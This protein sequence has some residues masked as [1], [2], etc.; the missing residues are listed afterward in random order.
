MA[1][2]SK[3]VDKVGYTPVLVVAGAL[4]PLAVFGAGQLLSLIFSNLGF[5]HLEAF[6]LTI[7]TGLTWSIIWPIM[8]T[9]AVFGLVF[10]AIIDITRFAARKIQA[11]Q[12]KKNISLKKTA[13]DLHH[14]K[15]KKITKTAPDKQLKDKKNGIE[16]KGYDNLKNKNTNNKEILFNRK[17]FFHK[18]SNQKQTYYKQ[19]N[20]N[21]KEYNNNKKTT[22]YCNKILDSKQ[23]KSIQNNTPDSDKKTYYHNSSCNKK[24]PSFI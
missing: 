4:L 21:T 16:L 7:S 15:G 22:R 14:G 13:S 3:L 5:F 17:N 23:L 10:G 6:A 2:F 11:F 19:K 12:E 9:L 1:F 8:V 20:Q 24:A 18:Q